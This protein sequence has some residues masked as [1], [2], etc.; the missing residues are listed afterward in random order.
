MPTV[1]PYSRVGDLD[2]V[3][4]LAQALDDRPQDERMRRGGAVDPDPHRR[5]ET[6]GQPRGFDRWGESNDSV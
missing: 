4:A 3:A 2:L 6:Y 5:A 1:W